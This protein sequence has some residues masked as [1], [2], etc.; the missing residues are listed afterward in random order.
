MAAGLKDV[1]TAVKPKTNHSGK[2]AID[3]A[4]L[5]YVQSAEHHVTI[6]CFCIVKSAGSGSVHKR[7]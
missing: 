7:I 6:K 4:R 3:A 2:H 1:Q 5:V